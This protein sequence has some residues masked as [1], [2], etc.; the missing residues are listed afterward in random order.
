M[1]KVAIDAGHDSNTAGK[2]TP[3]LPNGTVI[4]EHTANV[5]VAHLLEVELKR[6]GFDV[7]RVAWD[8]PDGTNDKYVSLNDR[9]SIIK[10][11]K[12]DISISI[13]FNAFGDGVTFNTAQGVG[14]YIHNKYANDSRALASVV[15]KHLTKGTAQ[16]NRGITTKALALCNCN[17]TGCKASILPEL[18]FMTNLKEATELLGSFDF[19][20]ECAIEIARGVC[21]YYNMPYLSA[22]QKV[23]KRVTRES[24]K[25]DIVWLQTQLRKCV[26]NY[27]IKI[28]GVYDSTTRIAVLIYWEQLGWGRHMN[29]DGTV[30]GKSTVLALAT[31][32][33]E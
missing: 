29:D 30:A 28:T 24:T 9:Q 23:P 2:R 27:Q 1:I 3:K 31:G 5:G 18:A 7:V 21:E 8:D 15:L 13:H 32:K 12:C 17:K 11:A 22:E 16:K 10:T 33:V 26:K 14:V 20:M 19:W 25:E 4:R 6:N